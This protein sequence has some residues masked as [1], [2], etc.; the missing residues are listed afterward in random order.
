MPLAFA[1]PQP[2]REAVT[3]LTTQQILPTSLNSAGIQDRLAAE[4]LERAFFSAT[5]MRADFLQMA[6]DLTAEIAA[7]TLD[8]ATARDRLKRFLSATGYS[9][10]EGDQGTIK[11]LSTDARL[12]LILE[13]NV[14]MARGYGQ[15]MQ[16][17][18]PAV[19]F[20]WPAQ[21]LY[22]AEGRRKPR[23]WLDEIWPG[24]GGTIFGD[25]MIAPKNDGI[26]LEISDFG[27]PYPPFKFNSGMGIKDVG[28]R[29]AIALGVIEP[30]DVIDPET[31]DFAGDAAASAEQ[32]DQG[33]LDALAGDPQLELQDGVLRLVLSE[34]SSPPPPPRPSRVPS[35]TPPKPLQDWKPEGR[36]VGDALLVTDQVAA[37]DIER[38]IQLVDATHGDGRLKRLVVSELSGTPQLGRFILDATTG[39][40]LGLEISATRE[41]LYTIIHEIGHWLNRAAL[42]ALGEDAAATSADLAAWRE[43]V[44]ASDALQKMESRYRLAVAAGAPLQADHLAYLLQ[45]TET[46]ARSYAQFIAVA[47]GD[48]ALNN[49]I[50]E[51]I[52]PL[53]GH[54]EDADFA[55]IYQTIV[56]LFRGKGWIR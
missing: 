36:L 31:R 52:T 34:P 21:E 44:F 43:A 5:V 48:R 37:G 1:Q 28:R 26:W 12:N 18:D 42:G 51:R 47:T 20:A 49:L 30:D 41:A 46:W 55:P 13:T 2:F 25:R 56:T 33:L 6:R 45:A 17:Q 38:G 35:A 54:W 4:L 3:Y 27:L 24:A 7:G 53:G 29:E 22:R 15:W 14:A 16:D 40:A 50:A 23:E 8:I 9:A 11:D 19:L 39:E 10:A 32:F